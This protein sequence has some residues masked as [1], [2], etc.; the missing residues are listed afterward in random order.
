MGWN[1]GPFKVL[2]RYDKCFKLQLYRKIDIVSIDRLK[3]A[4]IPTNNQSDKE[5]LIDFDHNIENNRQRN[6]E[7]NDN[8][9]PK[10]QQQI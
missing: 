4:F 10:N 9:V 1:I 3:S 6:N 5:T 2:E 8:A 7:E